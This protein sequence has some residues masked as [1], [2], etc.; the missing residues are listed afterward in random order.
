MLTRTS[1]HSDGTSLDTPCSSPHRDRTYRL[2]YP[3]APHAHSQ[4]WTCCSFVPSQWHFPFKWCKTETCVANPTAAA[5]APS[6]NRGFWRSLCISCWRACTSSR[7]R[8]NIETPPAAGL[9]RRDVGTLGELDD[10][11]R[12]NVGDFP[13]TYATVVVCDGVAH[14]R[15]HIHPKKARAA[16]PSVSLTVAD[17]PFQ[18]SSSSPNVHR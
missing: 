15:G 14:A 7:L 6:V 11:S 3:R 9:G 18:L 4:T 1:A 12:L 16:L 8:L 2:P 17:Q 13:E 10:S 5:I